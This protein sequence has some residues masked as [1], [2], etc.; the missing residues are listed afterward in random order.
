MTSFLKTV[1]CCSLAVNAPF[2]HPR[3]IMRRT[4]LS[5]ESKT[6]FGPVSEGRNGE[7]GYVTQWI[8]RFD[9]LRN[10]RAW[11]TP[12]WEKLA[13]IRTMTF[14][15][16]MVSISRLPTTKRDAPNDPFPAVGQWHA[17][18]ELPDRRLWLSR[19]K[20]AWLPGLE[21]G[22]EFSEESVTGETIL[23]RQIFQTTHTL[24]PALFMHVYS[25]E[26]HDNRPK[27]LQDLPQLESR[28]FRPRITQCY[29]YTYGERVGRHIHSYFA[30]SFII[31]THTNTLQAFPLNYSL[32]NSDAI[33]SSVRRKI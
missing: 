32:L 20:V 22:E 7:K 13:Q 4:S 19:L 1:R 18:R 33:P 25:T 29:V 5:Y 8:N 2:S 31:H 21:A 15:W 26:R 11:A 23:E 12:S 3:R 17:S 10:S 9:G 6:S 27:A 28:I 24:S 16:G 14:R 30:V